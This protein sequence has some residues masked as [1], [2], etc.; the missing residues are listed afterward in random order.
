MKCEE[1]LPAPRGPID[2]ELL[3]IEVPLTCQ[4]I[5]A[6]GLVCNEATGTCEDEVTDPCAPSETGVGQC[7]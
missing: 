3:D 2:M 4:S 7:R 5:C 6:P 1:C